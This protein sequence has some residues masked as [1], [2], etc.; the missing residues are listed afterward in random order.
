MANAIFK[1]IGVAEE[2]TRGAFT[3]CSLV[4]SSFPFH[5]RRHAAGVAAAF[6]PGESNMRRVSYF[7]TNPEEKNAVE[8]LDDRYQWRP[9]ALPPARGST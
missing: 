6:P 7:R 9:N 2:F 5:A 8:V 1:L 4:F 3:P